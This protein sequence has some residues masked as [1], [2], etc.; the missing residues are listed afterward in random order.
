M[1]KGP[2]TPER[3]TA[4][5]LRRVGP[6]RANALQLVRMSIK[7]QR[8]KILRAEFRTLALQVPSSDPAGSSVTRHPI[9]SRL[10]QRLPAYLRILRPLLAPFLHFVRLIRGRV[11]LDESVHDFG[12]AKASPRGQRL[13]AFL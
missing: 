3:A 9:G 5:C 6:Q 13:F 12:Q 11:Q 8:P 7:P 1:L 2:K 10:A 4:K